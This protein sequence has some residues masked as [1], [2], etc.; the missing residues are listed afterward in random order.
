MGTLTNLSKKQLREII[1]NGDE[2]TVTD[3]AKKTPGGFGAELV[4]FLEEVKLAIHKNNIHPFIKKKAIQQVDKQLDKVDD[5]LL[6]KA[7]IVGLVTLG[8][9]LLLELIFK[10]GFKDIPKKIQEIVEKLKRL[11]LR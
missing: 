6:D 1:L 7:G 11:K 9:F 4:D 5:S 2:E 3:Q 10:D 8:I